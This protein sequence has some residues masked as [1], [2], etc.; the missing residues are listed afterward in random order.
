MVQC[1][2]LQCC[3][4]ALSQGSKDVASELALQ[5]QPA[6]NSK[7]SNSS[8]TSVAHEP[9]QHS[10]AHAGRHS[11]QLGQYF[12]LQNQSLTLLMVRP[13]HFRGCYLM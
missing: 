2:T 12:G 6:C 7:H 3:A 4:S 9:F 13:W 1:M 8:I 10:E 5:Q 11:A